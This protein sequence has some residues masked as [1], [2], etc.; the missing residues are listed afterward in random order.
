MG[1]QPLKFCTGVPVRK[2]IFNPLKE[3]LL[4]DLQQL[5][6]IIGLIACIK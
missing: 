2:I 1:E 4:L 3:E 6:I 5:W